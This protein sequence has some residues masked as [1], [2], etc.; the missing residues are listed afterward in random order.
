MDGVVDQ[1]L[2]TVRPM[3]NKYIA[4]SKMNADLVIYWEKRNMQSIETLAGLLE[5]V[6]R[7]RS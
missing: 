2:N 1:Y 6:T 4:P 7:T 5:H 3:H